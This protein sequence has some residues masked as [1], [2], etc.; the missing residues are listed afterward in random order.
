MARMLPAAAIVIAAAFNL[1]S[2]QAADAEGAFAVGVSDNPG[3]DGI[4]Y[5]TAINYKTVDEARSV[6]MKN[7]RTYKPAPRA[8]RHCRL[9][10]TVSKLCYSMAFDPAENESGVGW[11]IAETEEEAERRAVDD[12]KATSK[13]SRQKFCKV[14]LT[15]CDGKDPPKGLPAPNSGQ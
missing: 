5:G 11:S 6:A 7:C 15:R 8:A 14:D 9:I 10:S 13:I 1:A 3:K 2:N 12:C 4:A